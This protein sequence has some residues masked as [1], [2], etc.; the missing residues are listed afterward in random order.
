ML[1]SFRRQ[2]TGGFVGLFLVLYCL[3]G[4]AAIYVF[5]SLLTAQLDEELQGFRSEVVPLIDESGSQPTLKQWYASVSKRSQRL[6]ST[7]QIFDK[8]G[9]LLE[10]YGPA[11][12]PKLKTGTLKD[13]EGKEEISVRS[14]SISIIDDK[15]TAFYVQ[16]QVSTEHR[17]NALHQLVVLMVI[18]APIFALA[19]WLAGHIFSARAAKPIEQTMELLR[20]FV[21]DA[22]HEF[23]TPITVIEA[24]VETLDQ[25]FKESGMPTDV[26]DVITRASA[27]MKDLAAKLMFLAK[28][29]NPGLVVQMVPL[30]LSEIVRPLR[31]QF[32]AVAA[33]KNVA[34]T[35]N[36]PEAI[37]IV[38]N[39]ES[40]QTMVSNLVDNALAYTESGGSVTV[41]ATHQ[42]NG[43]VLSVEDT[44]AGI[45][46]ESINHI[47]ER[48]YRVD[49]SRS[50]AVGGSGLGLSIVKAIV[51]AHK[52]T[53]KAESKVG[54]GSKFTVMLPSRA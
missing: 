53:I 1:D 22:G 31:D 38:G 12:I 15:G 13:K 46:L 9:R 50:R 2:L 43:V 5:N 28:M 36:V 6:Y 3:G 35:W 37:A 26:L 17:D 4:I 42:H 11:G 45:P 8:N 40:L 34:I 20:R 10:E 32:A 44:G 52:G 23:N 16:T 33:R 29:E 39:S 51:D 7:I 47:F 25:T 41:S 18:F 19:V 14:S 49:K 24:S 48:F 30:E 21:A 27:R 54:S